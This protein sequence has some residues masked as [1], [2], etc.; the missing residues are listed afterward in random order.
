MILIIPGFTPPSFS[1]STRRDLHLKDTSCSLC[2]SSP[3]LLPFEL[4]HS[5]SFPCVWVV[6]AT[7]QPGFTLLG[8][9]PVAVALVVRWSACLTRIGGIGGR[10]EGGSDGDK[11]RQWTDRGGQEK[12]GAGFSP[13]RYDCPSVG[14]SWSIHYW[15]GVWL[16]GFRCKTACS[17]K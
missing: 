2:P 16:I 4:P 11:N 7:F 15:V 1:V 14:P 9:G 10:R 12:G 17:Q 5:S 3:L 13:R 6:R 8:D